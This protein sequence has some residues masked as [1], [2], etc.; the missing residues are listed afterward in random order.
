MQLASENKGNFAKSAFGGDLTQTRTNIVDAA[1]PS[2]LPG[3][4]SAIVDVI[5]PQRINIIQSI[6]EL[7]ANLEGIIDDMATLSTK[8]LE[9]GGVQWAPQVNQTISDLEMRI[10]DLERLAEVPL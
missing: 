2:A 8:K 9:K 7:R 1:K 3:F 10:R 6:P 5:S 4:E